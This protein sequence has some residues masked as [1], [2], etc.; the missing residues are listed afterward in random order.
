MAEI[1]RHSYRA[2]DKRLTEVLPLVG[3]AARDFS[4]DP[5]VAELLAL[6]KRAETLEAPR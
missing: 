1:L 2:K 6:L 4:G 5:D 3:G